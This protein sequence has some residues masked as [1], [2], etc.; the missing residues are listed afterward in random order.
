MAEPHLQVVMYHY[1]RDV[2]S[3]RFAGLKAMR[4]DEFRQQLRHLSADHE[5]G[6]L[7]SCL[8]YLNGEYKPSRSLCLLTFDDGL[9]EHAAYVAPLLAAFGI[10]G[11]FLPR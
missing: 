9:F 5:M 10:Q 8:A 3:T 11:L 6:T 2:Q 7:E 4:T 1:V